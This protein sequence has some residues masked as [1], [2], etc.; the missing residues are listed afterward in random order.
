[1][2]AGKLRH[3]VQICT[4]PLVE[5][6]YEKRESDTLVAAATV[7]AEVVTL[8]GL[9]LIRAQQV[10]PEATHQVRL[11]FYRG[12]TRKHKLKWTDPDSNTAHEFDINHIDDVDQRHREIVLICKEAVT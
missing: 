9:E 1:M 12:L 5:T 6:G 2:Q 8:S 10:A 11:R 7:W 4:R 3:R